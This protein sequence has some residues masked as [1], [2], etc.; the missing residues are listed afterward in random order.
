MVAENWKYVDCSKGTLD[1]PE[2]R[3]VAEVNRE[4]LESMWSIK[5]LGSIKGNGGKGIPD[6]SIATFMCFITHLPTSDDNG[7]R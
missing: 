1:V 3:A 2:N 4:Q 6:G 5:H 7:Q